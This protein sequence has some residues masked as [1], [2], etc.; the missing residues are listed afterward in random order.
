MKKPIIGVNVLAI[1]LVLAT[2]S[3]S[4]A[5]PP[6]AMLL[7]FKRV[8]ADPSKRYQLTEEDGPWMILASS[9]AGEEAQ[10]QADQLVLELRRRYKLPAYV[11]RR[12]YDF[13][14]PVVGRGLNRRGT[15]PKKM[16]Y[17]RAA[18]FEQIAVL[19]GHFESVDDPELDKTL[20]KIKFARPACLD[21]SRQK[22][23]NQ[24]LA[25][26][27]EI[28]RRLSPDDDQRAKGPMGSAFVTRNPLLPDEYFA[29]KGLDP[30]VEEMNRGVKHSLLDSSGHYTVR[31]ATFRGDTTM[32]LRTIERLEDQKVTTSKLEEAAVKAHELTMSLRRRGIKAFEFHDRHESIVTV[33]SFDAL[34]ETMPDG[35]VNL[36]PAILQLIEQYGANRKPLP[37]QPAAGLTP[38]TLDGISFDIQPWP[39]QV[40]KRSAAN[41]FMGRRTFFR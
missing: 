37:G 38:K 28:Q 29:P 4:S 35:S 15:A 11:H 2:A 25:G 10:H 34:G 41:A 39:V 18:R 23:S 24:L 30:V 16:R 17:M 36:D 33:G 40:P 3:L 12:Q 27:R 32:D 21:V 20:E 22:A 9:F 19:V 14:E 6:L 13:T 31:V 26:L 8:E 5:A 1:I 7:P